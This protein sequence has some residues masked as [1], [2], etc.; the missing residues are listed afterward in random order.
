MRLLSRLLA[1]LLGLVLLLGGVALALEVLL[2]VTAGGSTLVP[3]DNWLADVR[4]RQWQGGAVKLIGLAMLVV[5]VSCLLLTL[6][7]RAPLA[8]SG[9]ARERMDVTFA[10]KPLESALGRLAE[11]TS[12]VEGVQVRVRKRKVTVTGASLATDLKAAGTQVQDSLGEGLRR[13]PLASRPPVDAR[14]RRAR[15]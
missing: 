9:Q 13:L 10:R 1:V 14:L 5:G 7:R 8:V 3:Y 6:R 15:S 4:E 2:T 11:R 12:G